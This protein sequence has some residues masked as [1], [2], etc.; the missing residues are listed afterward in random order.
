MNAADIKKICQLR[1][2]GMSCLQIAAVVGI[3]KNTIKSYLR[4]SAIAIVG[5]SCAPDKTTIEDTTHCKQCGIRL[6]QNPQHKP[7]KFCSDHCRFEWWSANKALLNKKA[8]YFITCACCGLQFESY[9]NPKRKYCGHA[10][11]IVDR[12][13]RGNAYDARAI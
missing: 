9:G 11:Y 12:F 2:D 4:R 7:R 13:K 3:P 10:C 5:A 8:L 1:H 6:V